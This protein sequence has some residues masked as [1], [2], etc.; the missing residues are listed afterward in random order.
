MLYQ[1]PVSAHVCQ[2]SLHPVFPQCEF[3]TQAIV[4]VPTLPQALWVNEVGGTVST[5]TPENGLS[6]GQVAVLC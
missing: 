1:L 6:E 3:P 2:A 5:E 4:W